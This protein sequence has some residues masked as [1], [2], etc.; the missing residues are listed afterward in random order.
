MRT[1]RKIELTRACIV[2]T[3]LG[4]YVGNLP[5]KLKEAE[6]IPANYID[7][8]NYKAPEEIK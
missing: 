1:T 7:L 5:S 3:A 4:I 8:E 6:P 2:G